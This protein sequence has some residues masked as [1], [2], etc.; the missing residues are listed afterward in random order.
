[1]TIEGYAN[2]IWDKIGYEVCGLPEDIIPILRKMVN[3]AKEGCR[4]VAVRKMT[5]WTKEEDEQSEDYRRGVEEGA[6]KIAVEIEKGK[7]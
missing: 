6:S 7:L 5:S 3:E 2:K 4:R 1:M